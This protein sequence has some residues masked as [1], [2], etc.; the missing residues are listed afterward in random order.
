[1]TAQAQEVVASAATM[2][3]MATQ[4]EG[5]VGRFQIGDAAYSSVDGSVVKLAREN[6][7]RPRL[8]A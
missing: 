1:M 5:L 2:A 7:R 3:D 4:L 8:A 6:N